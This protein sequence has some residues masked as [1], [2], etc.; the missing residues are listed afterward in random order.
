MGDSTKLNDSFSLPFKPQL[1]S[2]NISIWY[3]C[4]NK[5]FLIFDPKNSSSSTKS[6]KNSIRWIDENIAQKV[7]TLIKITGCFLSRF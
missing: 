5:L 3:L 2:L 4:S 1:L 6:T 7:T